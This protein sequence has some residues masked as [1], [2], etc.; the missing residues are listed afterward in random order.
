MRLGREW[1]MSLWLVCSTAPIFCRTDIFNLP[2][3][4]LST[5]SANEHK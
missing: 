4:T 5:L 1:H 3:D 2:I